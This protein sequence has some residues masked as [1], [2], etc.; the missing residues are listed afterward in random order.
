M[1]EEGDAAVRAGAWT[2]EKS[3]KDVGGNDPKQ[4]FE[5]LGPTALF[6][7]TTYARKLA[8]IAASKEAKQ[9][10]EANAIIAQEERKRKIKLMLQEASLA[11]EFQLQ[12][13]LP[14]AQDGSSK[15]SAFFA[16]QSIL[17]LSFEDLLDQENAKA[18][19]EE[20]C[21]DEVESKC[22]SKEESKR[23]DNQGDA[24]AAMTA[25]YVCSKRKTLSYRDLQKN[26]ALFDDDYR[27]LFEHVADD[28]KLRK[29][30]AAFKPPADEEHDQASFM[31]DHALLVRESI[32]R[33]ERFVALATALWLAADADGTNTMTREKYLALNRKLQICILGRH[34]PGF[35]DELAQRD[36]ELDKTK[37]NAVSF[38]TL[39][40]SLFLLADMYSHKLSE[41]AYCGF[42]S[43]IVQRMVRI[44]PAT[45][46][47]LC[48]RK[49][50]HIIS[51]KTFQ[52]ILHERPL[53]TAFPLPQ[54]PQECRACFGKSVWQIENMQPVTDASILE[55]DESKCV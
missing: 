10:E 7:R 52:F 2:E 39:L 37:G 40:C 32:L 22:E 5:E 9:Q 12:T 3:S 16:R 54:N 50:S 46:D 14:F 44:D 27:H 48:L 42:L 45:K 29:Q 24:I 35:C 13:P 43:T 20:P 28:K 38:D 51:R 36:W 25:Q 26:E 21:N 55:G 31:T 1:S 30:I 49:D 33:S 15:F 8:V 23:S 6:L 4:T 18:Q 17:G 11:G 34:D 47:C 53:W 41:D 19:P